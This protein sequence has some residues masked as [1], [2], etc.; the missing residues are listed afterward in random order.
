MKINE[1]VPIT[2]RFNRTSVSIDLKTQERTDYQ[3]SYPDGKGAR[4]LSPAFEIKPED[5]VT[6]S[7]DTPLPTSFTWL[8]KPRMEGAHEL[9]LDISDLL[10]HGLAWEDAARQ[11]QSTHKPQDE[12]HNL[13]KVGSDGGESLISNKLTVNGKEQ[14]TKD[15]DSI[16]IPVVV[17]TMWG[18]S[19]RTYQSLIW[20]VAVFAALAAYPL[21]LRIADRLTLSKE[22]VMGDK[23]INTGAGATIVNRSTVEGAFNKVRSE[24]GEATAQALKKI[25]EAI[26]KAG[27]E[28]AA[29]DFNAFNEEL[30]KPQPHK[31]VLKT[32]WD[33]IV[34]ALPKILEM[35]EVIASIKTLIGG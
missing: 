2:L 25:E 29:A 18:I 19:E 7:K 32:L 10:Y 8:I 30:Q 3:T 9:T 24:S 26:T 31:A 12:I 34:T 21:I 23:I 15:I 28:D 5:K 16:T 22:Q 20:T 33:G 14:S 6:K 11:E 4:L 13:I 17:Y 1:T 35:T 27:N